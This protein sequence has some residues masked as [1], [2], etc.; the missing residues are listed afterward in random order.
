MEG[1]GSRVLRFGFRVKV[2]GS[3]LCGFCSIS[4]EIEAVI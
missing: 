3:E 4:V 1:L 2:W